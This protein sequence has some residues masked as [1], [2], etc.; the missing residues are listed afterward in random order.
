MFAPP[1]RNLIYVVHG[2]IVLALVLGG[3]TPVEMAWATKAASETT[4]TGATGSP[5][6]VVGSGERQR[7]GQEPLGEWEDAASLTLDIAHLAEPSLLAPGEVVT[8]TVTARHTGYGLLRNLVITDALPDGLVLVPHS[9]TGFGYDPQAKA[10]S[11]EIETLAPGTTL[12]GTFQARVTG[13]AIG[14]RII[15]EALAT[16][17]V[18]TQMVAA[19]SV[20][21][22]APPV[23]NQA[24]IEPGQGG[25]LRSEDGRVQLQLPPGTV[26]RQIEI[27]YAR[28]DIDLPNFLHNAFVLEAQDRNG[29]G[30]T[31]FDRPVELTYRYTKEEM[32][33]RDLNAVSLYHWDEDKGEWEA[34]LSTLDVKRGYLRAQ[35]KHFSIYAEGG[36]E[37]SYLV[38]GQTTLQGAQPQL[39]TGSIGYRDDFNLPPG[40]GGLQPVLELRYSSFGHTP[41][42][43]HFSQVGFGWDVHRAD[44]QQPGDAT[45]RV[46]LQRF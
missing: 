1:Y 45:H 28:T 41:N 6:G 36:A 23:G 27:S 39:F 24:A 21:E 25:W 37:E 9:E 13:V 43:G 33:E 30:V 4:S 17:R 10:L 11:W 19:Q 18:I 12:T 5:V 15:N 3:L 46:R 20:V 7:P 34:V 32:A 2:L 31:V 38:E 44:G 40:Q 22:V 35:L 14:A 8:Y 16:S 42:I 29:E 26:D